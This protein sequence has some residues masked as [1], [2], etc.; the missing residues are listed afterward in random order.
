MLPTDPA[1]GGFVKAPVSQGDQGYLFALRAIVC[2]NQTGV[3][4]S[5]GT[6]NHS[7]DLPDG[8]RR[9]AESVSSDHAVSLAR[10]WHTVIHP[11][12]KSSPPHRIHS[13]R[14]SDSQKLWTSMEY[15]LYVVVLNHIP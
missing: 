12:F 14:A 2:P 9:I 4:V 10:G 8:R 5:V 15:P 6:G 3:F 13:N 7:F 1:S 11:V